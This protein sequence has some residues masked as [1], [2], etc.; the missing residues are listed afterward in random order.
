MLFFVNYNKQFL[1]GH[2]LEEES[3]ENISQYGRIGYWLALKKEYDRQR[4]D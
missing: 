1:I 3:E 2:H 4:L